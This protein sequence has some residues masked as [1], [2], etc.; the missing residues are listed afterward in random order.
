MFVA[1][2]YIK[3]PLLVGDRH[4]F[5]TKDYKFADDLT[6]TNLLGRL[7]PL[8]NINNFKRFYISV[9]II[10]ALEVQWVQ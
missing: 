1:L 10:H 8:K 7:S 9:S 3:N 5:S 4:V 2:L 6:T